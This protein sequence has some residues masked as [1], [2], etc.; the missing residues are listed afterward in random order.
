[1]PGRTLIICPCTLCMA[2]AF[3]LMAQVAESQNEFRKDSRE[4]IA[5]AAQRPSMASKKDGI[6][7]TPRSYGTGTDSSVLVKK[8]V[9]T[10]SSQEETRSPR[11]GKSGGEDS[12]RRSE[13][14]KSS[15]SSVEP[16]AL[17]RSGIQGKSQSSIINSARRSTDS[18]PQSMKTQGNSVA[19][20]QQQ[21]PR[22]VPTDVQSDSSLPT[23]AS[24]RSTPGS[25]IGP[26]SIRRL[27]P[28]LALALFHPHRDFITQLCL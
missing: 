3:L 14:S 12:T 21:Y 26:A 13:S 22:A 9:A 16:P 28:Q 25:H 18:V 20:N 23:D 1:M 15:R 10:E 24:Q 17:S 7:H 11:A 4:S 27:P 6:L 5:P 19:S 8:H 2:M